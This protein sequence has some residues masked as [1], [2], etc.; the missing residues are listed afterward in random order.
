MIGEILAQ[1]ARSTPFAFG[2]A[3]NASI[4][5]V[6]VTSQRWIIRRFNDTTHLEEELT[7]AAEPPT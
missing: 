5:H 3:D 2:G 7:T 6:V 4:S 1:A